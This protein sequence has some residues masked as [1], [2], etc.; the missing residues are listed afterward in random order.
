MRPVGRDQLLLERV[1][2]R[3]DQVEARAGRLAVAGHDGQQRQHRG[4]GE[5][6]ALGEVERDLLVLAA[7]DGVE[8]GGADDAQLVE[9]AQLAAQ[10][11]AIA[12]VANFE[13]HRDTIRRPTDRHTPQCAA[14][15]ACWGVDSSARA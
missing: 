11:D 12:L 4:G 1:V 14:A 2:L 9:A 5:R 15:L 8:D 10:R 7:L 6:L 3:L 13:R